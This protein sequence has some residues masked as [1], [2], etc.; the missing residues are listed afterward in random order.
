[1]GGEATAGLRS[2]RTVAAGRER[3]TELTPRVRDWLE[4]GVG[5][6]DRVDNSMLL[7]PSIEVWG[8]LRTPF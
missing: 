7:P 4:A 1:M 6:V 3:M 2:G 5:I 8:I